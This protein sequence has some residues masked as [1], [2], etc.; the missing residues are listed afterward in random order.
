MIVI[1]FIR[2]AFIDHALALSKT[3]VDTQLMIGHVLAVGDESS[4]RIGT[5]SAIGFANE[6]R[7]R[8]KT[9]RRIGIE[10]ENE[11]RTITENERIRINRR[12]E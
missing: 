4:C 3:N 7:I 10:T 5:M 1:S 9:E 6:N 8:S 11:L 12:L 2:I